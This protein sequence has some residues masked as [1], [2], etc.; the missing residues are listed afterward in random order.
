MLLLLLVANLPVNQLVDTSGDQAH[1]VY[2][3]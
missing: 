2:R 1:Q 3:S